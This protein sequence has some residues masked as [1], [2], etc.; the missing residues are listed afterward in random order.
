MSA[1]PDDP[2]DGLPPRISRLYRDYV[3]RSK[4]LLRIA[5]MY[6]ILI[7]VLFFSAI[8][9]TLKLRDL[10][11]QDVI[12]AYYQTEQA[13]QP[14]NTQ[15][16]NFNDV[17]LNHR[18]GMIITVG[19]NGSILV[20]DDNGKSWSH[21]DSGLSDD[22]SSIVFDDSGRVAVAVG[23]DGAILV[24][25]NQG[26][27]WSAP[28]S[29]TGKNFNQVVISAERKIAFAVGD[30]GLI[31]KSSDNG[32]T[33][34]EPE[35]LTANNIN[36]IALSRDEKSI[37]AV[38]DNGT[39]LFYE[40]NGSNWM[41]VECGGHGKE[42]NDLNAIAFGNNGN[43]AIIVG[44]NATIILFRNTS[45]SCKDIPVDNGDT[46]MKRKLDFNAVKFSSDGK[47]AIAVG[48]NG[49]IW[50]SADSGDNWASGTSN[51][52]DDLISIALSSD[53]SLAV[54][55]GE[56]GTFLV[57]T[58]QGKTWSNRESKT[59]SELLSVVLNAGDKIAI[60][61]GENGTGLRWDS[62]SADSPLTEREDISKQLRDAVMK[63]IPNEAV[64]DEISA[65]ITL[66]VFYLRTVTVLL[67]LL[68]VHHLNKLIRYNLRL[69]AFYNA[70][71]D[72]LLLVT[73]EALSEHMNF[74]EFEQL[75]R[76][77]SPDHLDLTEK[78]ASVFPPFWIK[79]SDPLSSS[80]LDRDHSRR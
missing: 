46:R 71:R 9:V 53:G 13:R 57:S 58:D 34:D 32:E 67:L 14:L 59:R 48:N 63:Q 22:L 19:E 39:I 62:L 8:W 75:M 68:M 10:S 50:Y 70:R 33:W 64:S 26:E 28:S 29:H 24:S 6:H 66:D 60:A 30:K 49:S 52:S 12:D 40:D 44:D 18:T 37:L 56:D 43:E 78:G 31:R 15:I 36:A 16:N 42:G 80:G 35:N 73:E 4:R 20:S 79:R 5:A 2:M 7:F 61:V 72:I 3:S 51:V 1:I 77:L 74:N 23:D 38:G 76:S 55:V 27:T 25:T 69:A 17:V 65:A 11:A 54:T 21:Q 47:T 41:S 45:R